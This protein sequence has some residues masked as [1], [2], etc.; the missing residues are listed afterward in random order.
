VPDNTFRVRGEQLGR[1]VDEFWEA[2]A[3]PPDAVAAERDG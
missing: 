2:L 3:P 1:A